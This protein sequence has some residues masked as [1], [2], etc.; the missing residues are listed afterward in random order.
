MREL[1]KSDGRTAVSYLALNSFKGW[2]RRPLDACQHKECIRVDIVIASRPKSKV[3]V[4]LDIC[5]AP[6]YY[7]IVHSAQIWQHAVLPANNLPLLPDSPAAK[8]HRPLAGICLRYRPT[9]GRRLSRPKYEWTRMWANAQRH[10]RPAE[11]R[12]RPLLN[13]AMFGWRTLLECRAV[14]LQI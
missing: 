4:N 9:E 7:S 5:K 1:K 13:A 14:T 11:Y 6:L 8:H 12:W 2:P 3:P 10:C